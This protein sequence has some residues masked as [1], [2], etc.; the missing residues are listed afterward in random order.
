MPESATT[1]NK[2]PGTMFDKEGKYL[3]FTMDKEEYGIG[4]LKIEDTPTFGTRL[5]TGYILDM[6]NTEG[7]V[8]I[9]LDINKVLSTD[10]VAFLKKA[11]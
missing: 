11:F 4:I 1:I 6:A 3:N 7:G 2:P 9:L 5:N 8:K 10:E